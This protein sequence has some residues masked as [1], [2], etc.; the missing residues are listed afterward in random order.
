MCQ[1]NTKHLKRDR[2]KHNLRKTEASQNRSG[3]CTVLKSS[4]CPTRNHNTERTAHLMADFALHSFLWEPRVIGRLAGTVGR[5]RLLWEPRVTGSFV[6]T[7]GQSRLAKVTVGA[8]CHKEPCKNCST[9]SRCTGSHGPWEPS[10]TVS[11]AGAA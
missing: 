6:R 9:V 5:T 8:S 4:I 7:P 3:C 2:S 11:I 1:N 10:V